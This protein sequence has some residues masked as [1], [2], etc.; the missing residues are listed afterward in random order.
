M[1]SGIFSIKCN[2]THI[3]GKIAHSIFREYAGKN[4]NVMVL[5]DL[6]GGPWGPIQELKKGADL[7]HHTHF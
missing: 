6:A 5:K 4:E 3:K 2:L 1:I 7:L